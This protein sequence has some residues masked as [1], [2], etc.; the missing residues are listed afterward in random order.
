MYDYGC[1]HVIAPFGL[2]WLFRAAHWAHN[3]IAFRFVLWLYAGKHVRRRSIR[4]LP[5]EVW[6]PLG[7][8]ARPGYGVAWF[9]YEGLGYGRDH[10]RCIA[11]IGL[12]LLYALLRFPTAVDGMDLHV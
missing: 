5:F 8:V 9:G 2:H 6:V 7:E 10:G 12:N 11:P 1:V 4:P 3:V